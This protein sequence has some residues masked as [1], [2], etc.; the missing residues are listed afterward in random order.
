M[1]EIQ[2]VLEEVAFY[3]EDKEQRDK[4]RDWCIHHKVMYIGELPDD[5]YIG[6]FSITEEQLNEIKELLK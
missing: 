4:I 6:V 5:D 2:I 3:I 1:K